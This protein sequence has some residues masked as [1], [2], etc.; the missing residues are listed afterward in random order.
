MTYRGLNR[1][2]RDIC[3]KAYMEQELDTNTWNISM[4]VVIPGQA[5]LIS[6]L[7]YALS[8]KRAEQKC[9]ELISSNKFSNISFELTPCIEMFEDKPV[10]SASISRVFEDSTESKDFVHYSQVFYS[11]FQADTCLISLQGAVKDKKSDIKRDS[12]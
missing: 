8:R 12:D 2:L 7:Y 5:P 11:L 1:F 4:R 9:L 10:A 3:D 6:T